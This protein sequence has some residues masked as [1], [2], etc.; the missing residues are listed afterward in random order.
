MA[1]M[2]DYKMTALV[3]NTLAVEMA[4]LKACFDPDVSVQRTH[5]VMHN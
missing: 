2:Y 5:C 4:W 3:S 1:R